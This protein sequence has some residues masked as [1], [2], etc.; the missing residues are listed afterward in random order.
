MIAYEDSGGSGRPV[1]LVHGAGGNLAD[2]A[3]LTER[4]PGAY[5]VVAVDLRGHGASPDWDSAG[6][7]WDAACADLTEVVDGLGLRAPVV[8]GMSLGGLVA[9]DW[10]TRTRNCAGIV[11]LDGHP[12]PSRR[13][14]AP[15]LAP[16]RADALLAELAAAFA[17][18]G[19]AAPDVV[20]E[21][22]VELLLDQR[23]R[24]AA[25]YGL[26]EETLVA[27]ARRNLVVHDGRTHL[28]P[29]PATVR[30]LRTALVDVDPYPR[31]AALACP[32]L[33]LLATRDL[34]EQ[35]PFAELTAA[36]RRYVTGR[37]AGTPTVRAVPVDASHAMLYE[38]PDEIA[39]LV[40][41]VL[42]G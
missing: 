3:P 39:R 6:W 16:D 41:D 35:Q 25:A 8:V 10:A 24:F 29:G 1:V 22:M 40:T 15:G 26:A 18:M 11:N 21:A 38:R 36:Y 30:A 2:W 20:P 28:R 34:P 12:T 31:Y 23:R 37:L 5:R 9:L 13:E 4:L 32:A 33:V 42:A 17:A 19:A 7:S 14:H 27:A